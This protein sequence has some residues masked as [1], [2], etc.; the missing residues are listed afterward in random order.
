MSLDRHL[1]GLIALSGGFV[2]LADIDGHNDWMPKTGSILRHTQ[3]VRHHAIM[4]TYGS[5]ERGRRSFR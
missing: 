1:S 2:R 3:P 5:S 4:R